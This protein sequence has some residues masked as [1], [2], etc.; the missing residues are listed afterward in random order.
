VHG[1]KVAGVSIAAL[2]LLSAAACNGDDAG[3]DAT[4]LTTTS[5]SGP[6][7]STTTAP[8]T[9]TTAV[10][11]TTTTVA[12]TTTVDEVTLTKQ[13]VAKAVVDAREAY[14]YAIYNVD[15]PDAVAR[16]EA[17]HAAGSPSL[18]LALR[19]IETLRTNGWRA[20]GNP[21]VPSA[22]TVEGDVVLLDGP[23]ASRA[24]VTVCTVSAGV[25]Y[26]PA[27]AP[28]GSDVIVNDEIGARRN[29][30]TLVLE[31]GVWKLSEGATLGEWSGVPECPAE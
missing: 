20:R 1:R 10:A 9:T 18:D 11:P 13:A 2:L 19:N 8:R 16:L 21:D 12:L 28:D 31:G 26:E 5:T 6:P 4:L 27:G 15:A 17:T 25:V 14:L 23:P 7:R 24:E 3:G 29:R 30:A 22:S